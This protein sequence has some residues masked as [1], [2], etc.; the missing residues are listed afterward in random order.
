MRIR[1]IV[2]SVLVSVFHS[3]CLSSKQ[4][5]N[6]DGSSHHEVTALGGIR[7]YGN[8]TRSPLKKGKVDGEAPAREITGL[9][10][11]PIFRTEE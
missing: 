11:I 8:T 5:V 9:W 4:T 2:F 3:A 1:V 10:G 6:A 7:V